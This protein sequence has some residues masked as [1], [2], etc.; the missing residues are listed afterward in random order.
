MLSNRAT[1][2]HWTRV[3][4]CFLDQ[5][6]RVNLFTSEHVSTPQI[7]V[8]CFVSLPFSIIESCLISYPTPQS[9]IRCVNHLSYASI[10][11][12]TRQS[13]IQRINHLSYMSIIYPT[14]Q[15]FILCVNHL[16][17][18]SIVY[19]LQKQFSPRK[20][21]CIVSKVNKIYSLNRRFTG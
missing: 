11:Y 18:A 7:K 12:P 13:F 8:D 1:R 5:R 9:F 10:T 3:K 19:P 2:E 15:S 20:Q 4:V 21:T 6:Q 17:D 14:S 16:F